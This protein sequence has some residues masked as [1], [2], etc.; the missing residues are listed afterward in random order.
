MG[1]AMTNYG[2]TKFLD[3]VLNGNA[4][5][6]PT[7]YIGVGTGAFTE[8]GGGGP[9]IATGEYA[10]QI[11][12]F[13]SAVSRSASND[14]SVTFPEALSSWGTISDFSLW[15]A[16]SGG[17]MLYYATFSSGISVPSGKS[18][19]IA[20]GGIIITFDAGGC[21]DYLANKWLDHS[22]GTTP[23]AVPTSLL[24]ALYSTATTDAGGGTELSGNGYTRKTISS[25]GS[26]VSGDPSEVDN[27]SDESF[28]PAS[29]NWVEATHGA[30]LDQSGNMLFHG[31]LG[32][33]VTILNTEIFRYPAGDLSH[34]AN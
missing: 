18:L 7:I 10:R 22:L 28:D 34:Q 6:M 13:S 25:Y 32:S 20:I 17:N 29:G 5:S 9:E 26:P 4:L 31:A 11:M 2:E 19:H 27:D 15:D 14:G 3:H 21:T 23:Y 1:T 8:A 16:L 33:P 24:A 30:I 12:T